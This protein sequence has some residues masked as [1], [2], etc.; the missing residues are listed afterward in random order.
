MTLYNSNNKASISSTRIIASA[1]DHYF[2]QPSTV[3]RRA[4]LGRAKRSL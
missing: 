2:R 1:V 4:A 3:A